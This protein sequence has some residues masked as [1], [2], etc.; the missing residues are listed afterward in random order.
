MLNHHMKH[1]SMRR[2]KMSHFEGQDLEWITKKIEELEQAKK[3]KSDEYDLEIAKT[4]E[5]KNRVCAD[6]QKEIDEAV[7]IQRQL[8]G[9]AEIVETKSFVLTMKPVDLRKPSQFKLQPSKIKE[10]KEQ[11]IQYLRN[12]HPELVLVKES[13][14]YKPKQ[15]DIKK[16]IADGVFQ[17]TDD[18]RVIDENGCY[19]PNLTVDIKEPEV[20]VK[21]KK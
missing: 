16:L 1:Q 18:L 3:I 7:A 9:N 13:T 11:F 17:L 21:V 4:T 2:M 8:M 19:I 15:L 5:R 20:K 6:L 12:E 10:E 14:E